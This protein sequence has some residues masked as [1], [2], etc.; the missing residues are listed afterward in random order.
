MRAL[1]S[2]GEHRY[3][4]GGARRDSAAK[5]AFEQ[6]YELTGRG[7]GHSPSGVLEIG[8]ACKRAV[9][10]NADP[11]IYAHAGTAS[12]RPIGPPIIFATPH[13]AFNR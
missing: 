13:D 5:L 8:N 4:Q 12:P 11:G 10:A 1:E 7:D 9:T 6:A 3:R 2:K